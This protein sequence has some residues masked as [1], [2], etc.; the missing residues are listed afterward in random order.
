VH[1][2]VTR[3]SMAIVP[4]IACFGLCITASAD[5]Q[6]NV[7]ITGSNLTTTTCG[8]EAAVNA[9]G[10]LDINSAGEM[11][12]SV[13]SGGVACYIGAENSQGGG[14]PVVTNEFISGLTGEG[15]ASGLQSLTD[16][17]YAEEGELC[18]EIGSCA[19]SDDASNSVNSNDIEALINTGGSSQAF[20]IYNNG[21]TSDGSV[22]VA[23][24]G[25]PVGL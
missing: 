19:V 15:T 18:Q 2:L 7:T 11:Y 21:G 9:V 12:L 4:L 6:Y 24:Q 22:T 23:A 3:G 10:T 16:G 5:T 13:P 20:T 25:A 14:V 1:N 8:A 17:W